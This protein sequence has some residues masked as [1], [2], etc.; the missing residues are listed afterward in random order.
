M[1]SDKKVP[2]RGW[3]GKNRIK[4]TLQVR[5]LSPMPYLI[6]TIIVTDRRDNQSVRHMFHHTTVYLLLV[7]YQLTYISSTF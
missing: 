7:Q 1:P 4:N 3:W 6:E 5:K 2:G